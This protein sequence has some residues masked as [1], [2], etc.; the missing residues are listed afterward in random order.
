MY[1]FARAKCFKSSC[2]NSVNL[3]VLSLTCKL[4][5]KNNAGM[6]DQLLTKERFSSHERGWRQF[7][8]TLGKTKIKR[9]FFQT[10]S[11]KRRCFAYLQK[12]TPC[13]YLPCPILGFTEMGAF[14]VSCNPRSNSFLRV[15]HC[16]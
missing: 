13:I 14:I 4:Q 5:I 3:S 2:A 10:C 16:W 6:F 12:S 7:N 11:L 9:T 8:R 15:G 1:F